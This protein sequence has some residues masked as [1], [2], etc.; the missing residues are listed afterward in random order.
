GT[1]FDRSGKIRVIKTETANPAELL[2]TLFFGRLTQA[3]QQ[4][5]VGSIVRSIMGT[6]F[7]T[8]AGIR[9]RGLAGHKLISFWDYHGSYVTWPKETYDIAKG[10][11]RQ[12]FHKLSTELE[13]RLINMTKAFKSY[14]EFLYV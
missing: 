13:N 2:D 11:R 14:P 1:D 9:S 6:H 10:L 5:Y 4:L 3:E 7:L 8:D 12:G